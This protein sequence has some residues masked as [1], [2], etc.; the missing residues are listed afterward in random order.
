LPAL[1]NLLYRTIPTAAVLLLAAGT[2]TGCGSIGSTVS[3]TA[4]NTTAATKAA[5]SPSQKPA[6]LGDAINLKGVNAGDEIQVT[7]VKIVD[8]DTS[9]DQ[10]STP[11]SGDRFVSVEFQIVDNGTNAY[12]DDPNNDATV[13]DAAGQ[14]FQPDLEVDTT[15]AGPQMDSS[16]DLAPGDKALG[17]ITF[18]VPTGDKVTTVQYALNGGMAGTVGEWSV[19]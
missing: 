9:T 19:G 17:Y 15:S 2:L 3:T 4:A 7:V 6:G 18:D 10:F 13:K 5:A 1:S 12:Q 11:D 16:T 14:A 8:P